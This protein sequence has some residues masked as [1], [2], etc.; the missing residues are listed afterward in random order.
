MAA[1]LVEAAEMRRG[2]DR[3]AGRD[4]RRL[5]GRGR[6][7]DRRGQRGHQPPRLGAAASR[8]PTTLSDA[9]GAQR[10]GRQRRRRR[11]QRRVQARRRQ[12]LRL[13]ARGLLGDRRRRRRDPRRQELDRARQRRRDRPHGRQARRRA[14]ARAGAAGCMEAYAGR[15]AM[16]AHAPQGA[17]ER[18]PHRA[19]Q[20]HEEARPR[21]AHLRA[22]G[23]GR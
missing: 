21:P 12:A 3:L 23:S 8:S 17:R 2:R 11:D 18:P 1:A 16:E 19:L 5:A 20:D 13:A 14:A 10:A 15:A 6:R 9:L 22:S 4:R 7:G